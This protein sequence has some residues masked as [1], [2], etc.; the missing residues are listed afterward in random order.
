M[1]GMSG[2]LNLLTWVE[3]RTAAQASSQE[4]GGV[5]C[6]L[7]KSSGFPPPDSRAVSNLWADLPQVNR[8]Q[9]LR[10]LSSLLERQLEPNHTTSKEG[11]DEHDPCAQ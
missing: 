1:L 3:R 11:E 7:S 5:P 2:L 9:L 4:E 8:K 6:P 10:L